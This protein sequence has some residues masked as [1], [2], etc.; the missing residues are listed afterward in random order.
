MKRWTRKLLAGLLS[1]GMLLQV[2]SPLSALAADSPKE[3]KIT[4]GDEVKEVGQDTHW[5]NFENEGTIYTE[6]Y[7][8]GYTL[9]S[10]WYSTDIQVEGINNA[11]PK[12]TFYPG[13]NMTG[14]LTSQSVTV[15]NVGDVQVNGQIGG[16]F[17]SENTGKVDVNTVTSGD[18]TITNADGDVW[19]GRIRGD[20]TVT[21]TGDI[22][23]FEVGGTVN[24]TSGGDVV[25]WDGNSSNLTQGATVTAKSLTMKNTDDGIVGEVNY[26]SSDAA[27]DYVVMESTTLHELDGM[28]Y[29]KDYTGKYLYIG[30]K[31]DT[32]TEAGSLTFSNSETGEAYSLIRYKDKR[33]AWKDDNK[34]EGID[35]AFYDN[36]AN[37]GNTYTLY[38]TLSLPNGTWIKVRCNYE[39]YADQGTDS[40]TFNGENNVAINAGVYIYDANNVTIKTSGGSAAVVGF[41]TIRCSGDVEITNS[42]NGTALGHSDKVADGLLVYSGA[43]DVTV[44]ANSSEPL[45]GDASLHN[46]G[47]VTLTNPSGPIAN[48]RIEV[49]ESKGDVKITG[50]SI[51][52]LARFKDL[53]SDYQ[54]NTINA[55]SV[56]LYNEGGQ[57]GKT[58]V[59]VPS[60]E[61]YKYIAG[62]SAEDSG[63]IEKALEST[64]TTYTGTD[65]YLYVGPGTPAPTPEHQHTA[66]TEW[67]HD[68]TNHWHTCAT[69]NE[70]VQLD[71]A[72]HSFGEDGVCECG[73]KDPNYKPE[74]QH[75][76]ST[77]WQHDD[78][79]HWHTCATCNEDVQLD[80]AAHSFGEDGVCECGY[81]D[82]DYKPEH[83]HIASTEWQHDDTYHWKTCS[84]CNEKVGK[85]E[86][87]FDSNGVCKCGYEKSAPHEHTLGNWEH[88][89]TNHWKICSGCNEKV[90]KAEHDFDSNG[91]CKECGYKKPA[92]TPEHQHTA[93]AE[94]KYDDTNHW[95]TCA[96]CNED[97]RLGEAPHNFGED[98]KAEKCVDCGFANPDYVAPD[99]DDTGT[100][101]SGSDAGGAVAAVLVGGAAVWGGY[102]IATRVILHNILPEGTAIPAN[103]GQL[104]LLV[105]NNAG[106]P[107]PVNEPAFADMDDADMAKA[108]QWCME[109]G[110]MEAKTAET[111]K[112]E[113][114]TPKLKVIEI[115]N[116]AFPKQ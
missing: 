5:I 103:R 62:E 94:W 52:G 23:T 14:Y 68:D 79:Y 59:Q 61:G 93:S 16:N 75:T 92:P 36:Y 4:I 80:K 63:R 78:T 91:I 13:D 19:V 38:G 90:G 2:A 60:T 40:V 83:Q 99:P 113:G 1:F 15:K 87:N 98:G 29:A 95:H 37:T 27:S 86:H 44:T 82:P 20:L 30:P 67:Q 55:K 116:K 32:T 76:A 89:G 22:R 51:E 66:S 71:K 106:R 33:V 31:T 11:T 17:T 35:Y 77:E 50:N 42:G 10:G 112:P 108:A 9:T 45:V 84:V 24:I 69:C 3:L 26:T 34:P 109:Q 115:W 81:K 73:Y 74:H 28:E 111:F 65:K 100:V 39:N 64:E 70:D 53:M 54:K 18:V 41:A 48:G 7:N 43:K 47:N 97:V 102:E 96:T 12:V 110:I 114:W 85:A 88:D 25:I 101:D 8:G 58:I 6:Y 56:T 105:W 72:A 57:I 107:E 21:N 49:S 46:S 104:A